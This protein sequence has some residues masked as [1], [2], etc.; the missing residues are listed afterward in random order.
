MNPSTPQT[1][2]V[3][4]LVGLFFTLVLALA[5][6]GASAEPV[7]VDIAQGTVE[8]RHDSEGPWQ[9]VTAGDSLPIPVEI[10][11]GPD[12][13]AQVRQAGTFFELSADTHIRLSNED[14]QA[15]GLV[16]RVKQWIGTVF[17]DVERQPDT[18]EVETPFLVSTVKGTQF[19]I[20]TTD[21]ASFV[22][23]KEGR[24][25]VVDRE[26]GNTRTLNPGDIA[27]V[28][29]L[30]ADIS[31][32][33]QIPDALPATEQQQ[34]LDIARVDVRFGQTEQGDTQLLAQIAS[35]LGLQADL[36]LTAGLGGLGID[37]SADLASDLGADL[38]AD[39]GNE[40]GTDVGSMLGGDLGLD[41]GLD[42]V[43]DIGSDIGAEIGAEIG[44]GL[45]LELDLDLDLDDD[46]GSDL[47]DDLG[48][49]LGQAVGGRGGS[50][51]N[52]LN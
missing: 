42:L 9:A 23:L 11:T 22:T 36:G 30:Q 7:T 25:E 44:G 19:T 13:S 12:T 20:V 29:S 3:P 4:F 26:T 24:L 6:A 47:G 14:D 46:L 15:D 48:D 51:N 35:S 49:D 43:A 5:S 33:L 37:A 50:V 21:S 8:Y 10:R 38:V 31:A 17:Y 27:S 28:S 34:A 1:A 40:L 39:L 41:L 52:L 18:F 32:L 16:S 2:P 45:G